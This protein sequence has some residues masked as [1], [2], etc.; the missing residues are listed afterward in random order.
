MIDI[1]VVHYQIKNEN[2]IEALW[3]TS[4]LDQKILCKGVA[5]GD[6]TNGF[7]GNYVVTY[8]NP[9]GT[10]RSVFNLKIEKQGDVYDLSWSLEGKVLIVGVGLETTDGL[11]VGWRQVK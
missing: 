6:T 9:D 1:G 3:Y 11:S 4:R 10:E 5:K 8:F 7:P 2:E